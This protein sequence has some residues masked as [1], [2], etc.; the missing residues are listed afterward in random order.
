[1]LAANPPNYK[2][3]EKTINSMVKYLTPLAEKSSYTYWDAAMILIRE[4]LEALLVVIAL[5]SFVKKS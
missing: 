3:A 4:G 2:E 1:M 5:M